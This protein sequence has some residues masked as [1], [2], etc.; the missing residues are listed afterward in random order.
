MSAAM[1]V[2]VFSILAF[3]PVCSGASRQ[4][5]GKVFI[6]RGTSDASAAVALGKD[7][8]IVADD[9]NNILRVYRMGAAMPVYS[10]NISGFLETE[11]EHPEA[12]IEGATRVGS[13]IYWISSHGRNKDGKLRPNRYRFFATDV[14][15]R[16]VNVEIRPVGKP[17]KILARSMLSAGGLAGLGLR[18]ATMLSAA[19][20]KRERE[21][22]APKREGLNIEALFA[23]GHGRTIYIG[24]RNP[25]PLDRATG[26]RCALVVPL[27][28]PSDVV[29]RGARPLFGRPI[30]WDLGGLGIR[31]VEYSSFH[32]AYFVVAGAHDASPLFAMYRWSGLESEKHQPI[33][34][35]GQTNFT[36]ETLVVFSDSERVLLL[37]DDGSIPVSVFGPSECIQGKLN[38]D[39]TCPNKYLL[40]PQ[41]K[42]FRAVWFKP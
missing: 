2:I 19:L 38:E 36:P 16:G 10:Y 21:R 34:Q 14:Q 15:I 7:M 5:S 25:R 42:T 37:S 4:G 20:S 28:N 32:G 17:C 22:L 11:A 12:D 33:C 6:F 26:R 24:F 40:D 31:A 27:E 3:G 18:R 1:G 23:S 13:R 39:G 41:K 9:E 29:E 8:F 30:L 35:L